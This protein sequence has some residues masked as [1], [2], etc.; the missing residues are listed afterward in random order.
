MIIALVNAP[1]PSTLFYIVNS[2]IHKCNPQVST[3]L[4]FFF[5][6][7]LVNASI[8]STLLHIVSSVICECNPQVLILSLSM[9]A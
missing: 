3:L 6:T 4:M 2:V 8:M 5:I 1:I 7:A 9:D